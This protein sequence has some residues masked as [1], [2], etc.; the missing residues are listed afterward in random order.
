MSPAGP[1]KANLPDNKTGKYGGAI[2]IKAAWREM[3]TPEWEK[4][5][6]KS[7]FP[8]VDNQSDYFT[9][10]VLLY[11]AKN[12]DQPAQCKTRKMGLI[13]LH[14]A[15]KTH[16][17]PQWIW[18]TF[19]FKN[20][21]PNANDPHA[22]ATPFFDPLRVSNGED[23]C[24]SKPFLVS[25][26]TCPN[27]ELNRLAKPKNLPSGM[28]W[29]GSDKPNQITRLQAIAGSGLNSVFNKKLAGTPFEN[30]VL[31]NTQWPLN[32]RTVSGHENKFNCKDNTLGNNCFT[33][34]PKY[35]RNPVVESYMSSYN[36]QREQYSNRS[37]MGCHF[38][39]GNNASY[40]WLDA[41][42][43]VVPLG[44]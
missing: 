44:N 3:C 5:Y 31:L 36:Y 30:Y 10:D 38:E 22:Q 7:C 13:A 19:S 2:E 6:G 11:F 35:L 24:W 18:S 23:Q 41:V 16:W 26:D 28:K 9:R 43:Q 42:E 37:C 27:V 17:A 8:S 14:I 34:I 29:P 39:A 40:I 1:L 33:M 21:V 25:P 15:H 20:N 12:G 4:K 32:G